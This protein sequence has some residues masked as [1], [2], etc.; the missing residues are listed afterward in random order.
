[1]F[2]PC[3]PRRAPTVAPACAGTSVCALW[4]GLEPAATQVQLNLPSSEFRSTLADEFLQTGILFLSQPCVIYPALTAVAVWGL[5]SAS[6]RLIT[7][8]HSAFYVS[9]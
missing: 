4:A 8:A 3:A 6:V 5:I 1:M 9:N 7:A 2:Q